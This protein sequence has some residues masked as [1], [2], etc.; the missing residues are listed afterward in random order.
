MTQPAYKFRDDWFSYH[1]P[2][3]TE[4][5]KPLKGTACNLLEIGTCEGRSAFWMAD[6]FLGTPGAKLT[7]VDPWTHEST[8]GYGG[9][10]EFDYN[11]SQCPYRDKIFKLRGFS[12]DILPGLRQRF[13]P[14]FDFA[15]IDG[16]HESRD[17]VTDWVNVLPLLGQSA[18][19]CFDDYEWRD[20]PRNMV[21][22]LPE[23][24]IDA[25]LKFWGSKIKVLHKGYQ[26]WIRLL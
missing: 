1:V 13:V 25:V 7:C 5:L 18:L 8:F 10:A 19:V 21:E 2:L 23:F 20:I 9:E 11:L 4:F 22:I 14:K 26:V 24:G 6:N 3:W 12:S 15:Y 16:S 17:L